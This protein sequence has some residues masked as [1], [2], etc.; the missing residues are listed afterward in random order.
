M[1]TFAIAGAPKAA[2][3]ALAGALEGHPEIAF[4]IPKEPYWFGSDLEPLRRREGLRTRADYLACFE[5]RSTRRARWRGEA[6]TLYLSSPDAIA[7][8]DEEEPD[9]LVICLVRNPVEVAHA[10]HMQMVYAGFE[11]L[12]DFGE[13]WRARE[14][15]IEHPPAECP[16]PRLLQY[17][18]I[19]AL[20]RQT[21]RVIDQVG[22]ERSHVIVYDDVMVDLDAVLA[23]LGSRLG[24]SSPLEDPG[25]VNGAMAM[26]SPR[27]ARVLRSGAGRRAARTAKSKLPRRLTRTLV[28]SKDHLLRQTQ[29]RRPLPASMHEEL[30]EVFTPEV[31]RLE[32]LLGRDLGHW[33]EL[34]RPGCTA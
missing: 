13:A 32:T 12:A 17:E 26:R 25:R 23:S 8:L 27:L 2:T 1:R 14:R 31:R 15:R 20:G 5:R 4:S 11:P 6:S 16:V 18:Q 29:A 22:T 33:L 24:L 30:V 10:F 19:A 3:T 34:S 21:E 7:Q 9:S 28:A